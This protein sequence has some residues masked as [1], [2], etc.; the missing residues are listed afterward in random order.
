VTVPTYEWICTAC[1]EHHEHV[2]S[3]A[4]YVRNPPTFVHCGQHMQRYFTVAPGTALGNALAGDRHYDGMRADD[5]TDI[6]TRSKHRQ[7]MKERGLTTA[8]DFAQTWKRDAQ[9][10]AE[11]LAG[12]DP[13]RKHDVA[14]AIEK[15]G[16]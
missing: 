2:S 6:S 16:G 5:G 1:R 14:G 3:I 9:Q 10:R 8:D 13:T 11:R 7:Y 15:L 4:D 12:D